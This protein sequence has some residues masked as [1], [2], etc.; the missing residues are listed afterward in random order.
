MKPY[1]NH[2]EPIKSAKKKVLRRLA[3]KVLMSTGVWS[4]RLRLNLA[5]YEHNNPLR[6]AKEREAC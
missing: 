1:S 2:L 5:L 6:F 4:N 3:G